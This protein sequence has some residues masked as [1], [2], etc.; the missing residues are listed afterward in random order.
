MF[1]KF[2]KNIFAAAALATVGAT[3]GLPFATGASAEDAAVKSTA[4]LA[5]SS[6]GVP[7]A[8][9]IGGNPD[10][11]ELLFIHGYMSSTLNWK[12][13]LHSDLAKTHKLVF[14][15][16]RGHGSSGKPWDRESYLNTQLFADDIAA[17][18]EAAQLKKPVLVAWSYGG[19]FLMDYIRHYGTDKVAGIALVS[20]DGGF[21]PAPPETEPSA[22]YQARI[23]RSRS[24]NI[25]VIREWTNGLIEYFAKDTELPADEIELLRAS[26]LLV[27]H[28][29]RRVMRDRPVENGDIAGDIDVPV[30]FIAGAE[31]GSVKSGG[32]EKAAAKI[33][34][35]EIILYENLGTMIN[36]HAPDRFNDDIAAFVERTQ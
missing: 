7:I 16:V 32:V 14:V 10:G 33:E 1:V 26:A 23:D 20:A 8:V 3:V 18:I 2:Y 17:A 21:L 35:S 22:E 24:V 30:L 9:T 13:Q 34:Q 27:P 28:H 25:F 19:L 29:V 5:E 6:D 11:E 15:D 36:W 31:D 4:V 12:K